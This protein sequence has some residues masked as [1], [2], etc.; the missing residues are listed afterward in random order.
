MAL[1]NEKTLYVAVGIPGSGKSYYIKNKIKTATQK[2]VSRDQIR[3]SLVKE[4]EPYFAHENQVF[5]KFCQEIQNAINDKNISEI[6][7]DATH[8]NRR[9]RKKLFRALNLTPIHKIIILYFDTPIETALSRNEKREGRTNVPESAVRDMYS[10][11][12][13]PQLDEHPLIKKIE[14]IVP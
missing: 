5:L 8:L 1:L 11:L 2:W 9:S 12:E 4:D 3:F 7:A 10:R 14:R 6:Y 13:L